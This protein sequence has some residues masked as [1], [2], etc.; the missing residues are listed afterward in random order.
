MFGDA[1]PDAVRA[2]VA[3]LLSGDAADVAGDFAQIDAR[4]R[5][6]GPELVHILA[7]DQA[8]YRR[9]AANLQG[10]AN[11]GAT[12]QP[13][14]ATTLDGPISSDVARLASRRL[15]AVVRP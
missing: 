4:A 11:F 1:D 14:V 6:L 5:V 9:F 7:E 3:M 13:A 8:A 10:I 12:P 15:R 2:E